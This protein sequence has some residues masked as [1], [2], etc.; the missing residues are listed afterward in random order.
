MRGNP[1]AASARQPHQ[2][3]DTMEAASATNPSPLH[4]S[5]LASPT[6]AF[7]LASRASRCM[8]TWAGGEGRGRSGGGRIW[9]YG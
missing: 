8:R 1:S 9:G 2:L 4:S 6:R 3:L 5:S 7:F